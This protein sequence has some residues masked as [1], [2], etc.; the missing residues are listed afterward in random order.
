M[1][2]FDLLWTTASFGFIGLI[3]ALSVIGN[4]LSLESR[5]AALQRTDPGR[6]SALLQAQ[7]VSDHAYGLG[8]WIPEVM[9]VCTPS[10]RAALAHD[11]DVERPVTP[12]QPVLPLHVAAE[13]HLA[14]GRVRTVP[15]T[16]RRPA[17]TRRTSR[18]RESYEL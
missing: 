11:D 18:R 10:R 16:T 13:A 4:R 12:P 14:T 6:A 3:V 9:V 2:V 8:M 15:A 17:G 1:N 5:A 7:A